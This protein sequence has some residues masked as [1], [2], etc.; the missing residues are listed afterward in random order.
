MCS[1]TYEGQVNLNFLQAYFFLKCTLKGSADCLAKKVTIERNKWCE[2][3]REN[4]RVKSLI[5]KVSY[6]I[7]L[8]GLDPCGYISSVLTLSLQ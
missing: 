7:E 2:G 6:S 5:N 4:M 1:D 3:E 8:R